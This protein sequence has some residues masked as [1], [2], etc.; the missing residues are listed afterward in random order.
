MGSGRWVCSRDPRTYA[1][2]SLD[3]AQHLDFAGAWDIRTD[4]IREGGSTEQI[5]PLL[6][7]TCCI[8]SHRDYRAVYSTVVE[9]VPRTSTV[10]TVVL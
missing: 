3:V 1:A 4:E 2:D 9:Y 7:M 10:C 6:N 8:Q 5:H